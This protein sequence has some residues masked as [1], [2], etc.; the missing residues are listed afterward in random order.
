MG[1]HQPGDVGPIGGQAL[2]EGVMMRRGT[3]WGAAVRRLDG[4]IA[5]TTRVLPARLAPWRRPPLVRG[6]VALGESVAVG[7]AALLWAAR[8]RGDDDHRPPTRAGL[9]V[10]F[11][12]AIVL[13][14]G[15]FG[16]APAAA[17]KLLGLRRSLS[18]NAVEGAVRL[19]LLVAYLG[20]LSRSREIRRTFAYHGA[21]HM[22]IHA[23]EHRRPLV[24]DEIE[25]FDRRHPRC[26]TSFLMLVVLTS[27]AVHALI[28][29]PS[30][31]VLV[32]SRIL[33]LPVVAGIAYEAIRLAGRH[34]DSWYARVL[35]A[36]GTWLQTITTRQP[37]DDQMEVAVA[38]LHATLAAEELGSADGPTTEA[39][40]A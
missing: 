5:T 31:P 17:A 6:V 36:P 39:A 23:F 37:D 1:A 25:R 18:F 33:L 26:G 12:V 3:C 29:T 32:A 4:S 14:V 40:L 30:W 21:E 7:T 2:I 28:G 38:A 24:A 15:L 11:V 22:T 9:A 35:A 34:Q 19:S 10:S 20:L 16:L 8:E 13:A 27:V